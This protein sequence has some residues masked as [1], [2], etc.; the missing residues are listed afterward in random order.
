MRENVGVHSRK[1]ALGNVGRLG[2]GKK[3]NGAGAQRVTAGGER[4]A[5]GFESRH[6]GL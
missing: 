4:Q 6:A 5:Q 1:R 3:A 2:P